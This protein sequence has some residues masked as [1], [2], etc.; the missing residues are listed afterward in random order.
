MCNL[1]IEG[2]LFALKVITTHMLPPGMHYIMGVFPV[3][4]RYAVWAELGV[5]QLLVPNASFIGEQMNSE[6]MHTNG[7]TM[8][9]FSGCMVRL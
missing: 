2:V 1:L 7:N 6:S 3:P 5:I 9:V 4:S 8:W